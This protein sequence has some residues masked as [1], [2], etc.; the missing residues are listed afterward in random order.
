MES[1]R[2][3]RAEK[4]KYVE[5]ENHMSSKRSRRSHPRKKFSGEPPSL[6]QLKVRQTSRHTASA[7]K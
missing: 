5:F 4:G 6:G 1:Q 3:V 7:R 2:E